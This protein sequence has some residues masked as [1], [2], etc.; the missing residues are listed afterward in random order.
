[1]PELRQTSHHAE[2]ASDDGSQ[3]GTGAIPTEV[4]TAIIIPAGR[5]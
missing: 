5:C 1:L 4:E 3:T 2:A